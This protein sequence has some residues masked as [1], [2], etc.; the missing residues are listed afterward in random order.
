MSLLRKVTV[1]KKHRTEQNFVWLPFSFLCRKGNNGR[2]VKRN[3][4]KF[5]GLKNKLLHSTFRSKLNNNCQYSTLFGKIYSHFEISF[6]QSKQLF[7]CDF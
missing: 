3:Q 7:I 1:A 5:C 6:F 4:M 2:V